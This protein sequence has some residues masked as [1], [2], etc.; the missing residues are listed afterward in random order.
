MG[1]EGG[2]C[3]ISSVAVMMGAQPSEEASDICRIRRGTAQ[4][5]VNQFDSVLLPLRKER[6]RFCR[7]LGSSEDDISA[8]GAK[9]CYDESCLQ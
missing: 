4:F 8:A 9:S 6:G 2:W 3:V 1:R 5:V 7:E